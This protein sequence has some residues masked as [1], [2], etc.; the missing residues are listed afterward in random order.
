VPDHAEY[1]LLEHARSGDHAAFDRLQ[2]ALDAPVRRF[3]RRLIGPSDAEDDIVRGVFLALYMNL[4]RLD[5]PERLRPFVFRVVRNLCYDELRR[6]GRFQFVSLEGDTDDADAP[7]HFLPDGRLP[8]DEVVHWALLYGE[9]QRAMDRLPELQRQALILYSEEDLTYAQI[10][11]AMATD[12]G[13]VKSR[14][15][16]ARKN[17]ARRLRPEILDAL[18]VK[19]E[20]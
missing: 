18:G 15:H 8:P 12:I 7:L 17:L 10:A 1:K 11:E 20:S 13:T 6:K 16:H 2:M 3:V 9:V 5:R 14:I 19:K 4:E